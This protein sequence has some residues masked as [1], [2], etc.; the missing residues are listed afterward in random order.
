MLLVKKLI[1]VNEITIYHYQVSMSVIRKK[2][3]STC[4]ITKFKISVFP[5]FGGRVDN[6]K[7]CSQQVEIISYYL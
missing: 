3:Q 4:L 2:A 6:V 5:K 7:T 1:I